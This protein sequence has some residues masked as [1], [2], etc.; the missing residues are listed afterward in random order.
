MV[1]IVL[2]EVRGGVVGFKSLFTPS[3]TLQG[4]VPCPFKFNL[5]KQSMQMV[6]S[7]KLAVRHRPPAYVPR[8]LL[9]DEAADSIMPYE[10]NTAA[11]LVAFACQV[12]D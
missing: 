11:R 2:D 9:V 12:F 3:V 10:S 4:N 1:S 6:D 7:L 5:K 8:N